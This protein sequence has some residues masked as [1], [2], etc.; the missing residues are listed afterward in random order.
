MRESRTW[1][2]MLLILMLGGCSSIESED[3]RSTG[4]YAEYRVVAS[5]DTELSV[6]A[7]LKAGGASSNTLVELAADEYFELLT[8]GQRV[9][10]GAT[11]NLLGGT[12]YTATLSVSATRELVLDL[13]LVR[14]GEPRIDTRFSLPERFEITLP[15]ANTNYSIAAAGSMTLQWSPAFSGE[16]MR[17]EAYSRCPGGHTDYY[18]ITLEPDLGSHTLAVREL[19]ADLLTDPLINPAALDCDTTLTLSRSRISPVD[20]A[21]GGGRAVAIQQRKLSLQLVP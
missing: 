9:Q 19:V 13:G 1:G 20:A 4:L 11:P 17:I 5:N 16:P 6:S 21:F 8:D 18:D 7:S 12:S 15:A 14:N 3:V 10:L 2:M